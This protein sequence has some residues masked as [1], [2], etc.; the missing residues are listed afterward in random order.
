MTRAMQH[1]E[2]Q[3]S[4]NFTAPDGPIGYVTGGKRFFQWRVRALPNGIV[5]L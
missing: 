5:K 3:K 4:G 2:D 1:V